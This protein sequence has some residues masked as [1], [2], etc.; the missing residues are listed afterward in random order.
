MT[1][2]PVSS[3]KENVKTPD[4]SVAKKGSKVKTAAKLAAGAAVIGGAVY[5]AK[6]GKFNA[7]KNL[8][9]D[10]FQSVAKGNPNVTEAQHN[11]KVLAERAG[12]ISKQV[13]KVGKEVGKKA[14][15]VAKN[16]FEKASNA[17]KGITPEKI[18]PDIADEAAKAAETFNN[19]VK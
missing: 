3:V 14:F 16:V 19:F 9:E 7:A 5:L 8:V 1:P 17:V 4:L 18:N 10:T 6:T 13:G 12:K 11:A 2:M 15:N